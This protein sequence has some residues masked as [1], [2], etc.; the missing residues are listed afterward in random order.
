MTRPNSIYMFS[1]TLPADYN[2]CASFPNVHVEGSTVTSNQQA[3][4]NKPIKLEKVNAHH[5][6]D[7]NILWT[8]VAIPSPTLQ[9]DKPNTQFC[10][11]GCQYPFDDPFECAKQLWKTQ[12]IDTRE[13]KPPPISRIRSICCLVVGAI[14]L[15]HTAQHQ[16]MRVFF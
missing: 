6:T 12:K 14:V 5:S 13:L 3:Q 7:C 10:A 9:I 11:M 16:A 8:P 2:M 4:R 15:L 1:G